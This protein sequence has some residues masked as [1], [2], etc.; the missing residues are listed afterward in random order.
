MNGPSPRSENST[1]ALTASQIE[2]PTHISALSWSAREV[3][4]R[5]GDDIGPGD[6]YLHNDPYTGGSHLNDVGLFYPVFH[7]DRPLVIVAVMAHWQDIGG[8]VPGSLCGNATE[9]YQEGIR[10]PS[11]RIVRRGVA[12]EEVLDLL[13]ANVRGPDD[14]RGDLRAMEGACR[15]AERHLHAMAD[16]WG[17]RTIRETLGALLDRA[18]RRMRDAIG[19]LPD[20]AYRCETYLDNSGDSPEPLLLKLE[21]TVARLREA[22][23][24]Y[25][26]IQCSAPACTINGRKHLPSPSRNHLLTPEASQT[27][28]ETGDAADS[29]ERGLHRLH[30][31]QRFGG[32]DHREGDRG[33][34]RLRDVV[35]AVDHHREGRAEAPRAGRCIVRVVNQAFR[36]GPG[37]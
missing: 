21:L 25:G 12:I 27:A 6:L 9:I 30:V 5:Y 7:H 18:E 14:R 1:A 37:Y 22:M 3:L 31:L 10:I 2:Q 8:M 16:Q 19:R 23:R 32:L 29:A 33:V 11:L 4:A 20:G 15:I 26:A 28:V 35:R 17:E 13:F 24:V 36:V 34:V